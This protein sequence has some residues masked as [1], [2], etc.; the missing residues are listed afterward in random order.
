MVHDVYDKTAVEKNTRMWGEFPRIL[1]EIKFTSLVSG[2]KKSCYQNFLKNCES[3][4]PKQ[5]VKLKKKFGKKAKACYMY[6]VLIHVYCAYKCNKRRQGNGVVPLIGLNLFANKKHWNWKKTPVFMEPCLLEPCI[7]NAFNKLNDLHDNIVGYII[8][9][10]TR[11]TFIFRI[12]LIYMRQ[13]RQNLIIPTNA[14][15]ILEVVSAIHI[16]LLCNFLVCLRHT[17]QI[18]FSGLCKFKG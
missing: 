3:V 14:N 15:R 6:I 8:M 17:Y 9:C 1:G 10:N 16:W 18:Q 7:N 2:D 4:S 11:N 12:L 13:L 5:S